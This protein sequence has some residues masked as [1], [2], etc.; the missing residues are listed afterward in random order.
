MTRT[1]TAK[2]KRAEREAL[3]AERANKKPK[4]DDITKHA[5]KKLFVEKSTGP[6]RIREAKLYELLGSEDFE[7]RVLAAEAV[8]SSLFDGDG[9]PEPV[10]ERHLDWRLFRGLASGR[11]ASRL[12]YSLVIAEVLR[13][14]FGDNALSRSKYPGLTLDKVL[15]ILQQRTRPTGNMTGQEERDF[16]FG[17]LFGL[18][19][20]ARA[21]IL[22]GN[23]AMW[24]TILSLLFKLADK[25]V[26]LRPQCGWVVTEA[27]PE[28][29]LDLTLTTLDIVRAEKWTKSPE[30][31][32]ISLAALNAYPEGRKTIGNPLDARVL[33]SLPVI[34]KESTDPDASGE[35]ET[36][37]KGKN[38]KKKKKQPNW[39]HQL[40]F[41]WDILLKHILSKGEASLEEFTVFWRR[42]VDDN[43]FTKT[44]TDGQKLRGFL[45][46]QKTLTELV[47]QASDQC[48]LES[49]LPVIFS[50]NLMACLMNQAAHEDRYLHRAAR[51]TLS[52]VEQAALID[53]DVATPILE[54][55]I[56]GNGV[57]SFD[58]RTG[59]KTV[60]NI[61]QRVKPE[62]GEDT[63]G[64]LSAPAMK[65]CTTGKDLDKVKLD[66]R[67]YVE[68]LFKL[69][70]AAPEAALKE[71]T[72]LAYAP[73]VW[74]PSNAADFVK[75]LSRNRLQSTFANFSRK[76]EDSTH[77][78]T[79]IENISPEYI[80]M[81]AKLKKA[82]G[83][84][85][86]K[87]K[88][89]MH[90]AS[91]EPNEAGSGEGNTAR[92]LS[93]LYTMAIFQIYN[94]EPDAF[95][96][97]GDLE[98]CHS[99][100]RK[101]QEGAAEFLV[102]ILLS[103]VS[104]DSILL[105]Q[106]SQ[107]VFGSFAGRISAA[108][109]EL[110]LDVLSADENSKGRQALF[111]IESDDVDPEDIEE[112]SDEDD[113]DD[114][115]EVQLD[116]D[117]EIDSDVE[118]VTLNG[119]EAAD[120]DSGDASPDS[121][122][123]PDEEGEDADE[124]EDE[125]EG[126]KESSEEAKNLEAIDDALG[127]ILGSHRL[128][129]DKDAASSD[130][131]A[132]MTDSEMLALDDK[133]A[134]VFQQRIKHSPSKKKERKAAKESVVNFKRR[135][136]A[137]LETYIRAEAGNPAALAVLLPLLRLMRTTTVKSLADRAFEVV[138][139]YQKRL[140]KARQEANKEK[141]G[142]LLRPAGVGVGVVVVDPEKTLRLLR[143]VH[144]EAEAG[145]MVDHAKAAAA[146]SLI[147]A[148]TLYLYV[149]D[150]PSRAAVEAEFVKL[151]RK[152]E[153]GAKKKKKG[154]K[155]KKRKNQGDEVDM[156]MDW[157]QWRDNY[158]STREGKGS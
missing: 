58:V 22:R 54:N 122:S 41:V 9:V 84:A 43:L 6:D 149:A 92:G 130:S 120:P 103:M 3:K 143:D 11:A 104:Q 155:A 76:N 66:L 18:E 47:G 5:E 63:V 87:L 38:N 107:Q 132:D 20:F 33:P 145:E 25:K 146:A 52:H 31:V 7:T 90:E 97:L 42:C 83:D 139:E 78:C 44:A 16:Y 96:L 140:R 115:E 59:T 60:E 95:Q 15:E 36:S 101:D 158:E 10:L 112:D 124:D 13:Q 118:F 8:I 86:R 81:D 144:A 29:G 111:N 56:T 61:V 75:E 134:A 53:Q 68:Y 135:V 141:G 72:A 88:S 65:T 71:L 17:Q 133:L 153:D 127:K 152:P 136:L 69:A 48:P 35:E 142:G 19:C 73:P 98:E 82:V 125:E 129:K 110:L 74:V 79:A 62:A 64:V 105:R 151:E 126:E 109:L 40:H 121:E 27:L 39:S 30:G 57:F 46:F 23:E 119:A 102:E 156:Y 28:L 77:L 45:V 137:L 117:V 138:K 93:L 116:S 50:K 108:A 94:A 51:K 37:T 100:L 99:R 26:W 150:G 106:I 114:V 148:S 91:Q 32:A 80:P 147:V 24:R 12:G 85:R 55:L 4:T 128:D 67:V 2:R 49:F 154:K 1:A 131:D 21:G 113:D 123:E 157:K 70:N 14:L 34:L 89:L